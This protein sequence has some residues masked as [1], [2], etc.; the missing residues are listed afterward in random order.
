MTNPPLL[1]VFS[2]LDG[3]LLD[4]ETYDWSAARPALERLIGLGCPVI[5]SSSKTAA[6]ILPLQQAMRLERFPA[7]VENGA[8]IIG[9]DAVQAPADT[10]YAQI[11]DRLDALPAALRAG[12]H[13]FGDM[14]LTELRDRTGLDEAAARRAQNRDFSEPGIWTGS[15]ADRRSFEAALLEQGLAVQQ[16]G[17]FLT[18]SDGRSKAD[19]M[20]RILAHYRPRQSLALGD[21]PNDIDMLQ[22]A[23][24]GIIINNPH[25]P[26]LPPLPGEATGR[27]TRT[28]LPG[29]EGWNTAVNDFVD[30][31]LATGPNAHG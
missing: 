5:L 3:T 23:G 9:L 25:R 11:R 24:F 30:T 20:G 4:H 18:V 10:T 22:T 29:P 16:G 19:G 2:D 7:I 1:V 15:E 12:F 6:E 17:R 31:H 13:G 14:T 28:R 26:P 21:A 27:I 8:G